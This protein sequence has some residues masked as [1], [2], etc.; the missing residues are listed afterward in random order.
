MAIENK[1][2]GESL[3]EI[4]CSEQRYKKTQRI[5]I[6]PRMF[7]NFLQRSGERILQ[8]VHNFDSFSS[9]A[10]GCLQ[11]RILSS[12]IYDSIN[13]YTYSGKSLITS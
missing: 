12:S 4:E 9:E 5:F 10:S 13:S 11:Q 6:T 3:K 7:V 1:L 2:F 8:M